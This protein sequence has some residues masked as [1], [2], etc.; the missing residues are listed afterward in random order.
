MRKLCIAYEDGTDNYI[1]ES[2]NYIAKND[3]KCFLF[4]LKKLFLF[5]RYWNF[6]LD[7]L[8]M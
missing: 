1:A 3:E 2:N 4:H 5:S 8:F 6:C 7:I